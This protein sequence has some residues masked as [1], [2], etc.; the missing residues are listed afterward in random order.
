LAYVPLVGGVHLTEL[1][2]DRLDPVPHFLPAVLGAEDVLDVLDVLGEEVGP[3]VPV[4]PGRALLPVGPERA[5]DLV[6]V[7]VRH[8]S[9]PVA[10]AAERRS[11]RVGAAAAPWTLALLHAAEDRLPAV[12]QIAERQMLDLGREPEAGLHGVHVDPGLGG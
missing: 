6:D 4:L 7:V 2:H 11:G 10:V 8:A 1:G 3:R 12:L 9:S 5:L